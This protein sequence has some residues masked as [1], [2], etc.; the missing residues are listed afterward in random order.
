MGVV[1]SSIAFGSCTG[2]LDLLPTDPN[3]VTP[4]TFADDPEAYLDKVMADVYL[5][6]ATYGVNGN[7]A[8][9]GFD[10]GMSTFQRAMFILEEIPSDEACWLPVADV[11]YGDFEYGIVPANNRAIFGTYSRLTINIAL[12]NDFISSVNNGYFHLPESAQAKADDFV[13][14]AK[15]LRSACYF[16]LIDCF[17]DVPYADENLG[18]GA[19]PPQLPRAE[20]FNNVVGTLEDVVANWGNSVPSYGYIGKDAAQALLVK[21]YLNAGVYTGTPMW[22]K[23]VQHANEII[24]R[25][26]GEGFQGS[27]LA[28]NYAQLFANNNKQFAPGGGGINEI[29]WTIPQN[30]PNLRSYANGTF[31]V[32]AW[33]SASKPDDSWQCD[34]ADY[35]ATNGWKCM[36]ARRQFVEKF[37][38]DAD[39]KVSPDARVKNWKTAA[40]G[41]NINNTFLDQDHYGNNGFLAVKFSNFAV[42]ENGNILPDA[43]PTATDQ[44]PIDYPV[45]R[46]AEI[47]LSAAEAILQGG[48]DRNQALTYVNY[49]RERANLQPWTGAQLNLESLQDERCRELYTENC[50]RTDLIRYGKWISGYT[51]SWKN[52]VEH[53][54]DF[55]PTFNLYPIPSSVAALAGY[56]QNPGY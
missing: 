30:E 21:F 56:K 35:N 6:F 4:G 1:A 15:T 34:P 41:F 12:C 2:D 39:F 52:K 50:R 13:R 9:Q 36:V 27:G 18:V 17:G 8:V 26:K 47:Y 7:A 23:C 45:I 5:Q 14:Q 22:D 43:S 44:L 33:L 24:A 31:M 49:I 37:D 55:A 42:D 25:H 19:V 32:N 28:M 53:G 54:A 16:Y 11:D 46:L 20:V 38:W 40:H 48:G 51:W 10:G 29:L 3:T